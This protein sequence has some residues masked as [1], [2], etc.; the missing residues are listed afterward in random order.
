VIVLWRRISGGFTAG[1]QLALW[2]ALQGSIKEQIAN[3]GKAI[4]NG[5]SEWIELIRLVGSLELLPLAEK[6]RFVELLN[7][8]VR[9]KKSQ[10]LHAGAWWSIG[11]L[12][13]RVPMYG[14]LSGVVDAERIERWLEMWFMLPLTAKDM[15]LAVMQA[16][17]RTGDRYRDIREA[18]R[19]EVLGWLARLDAPTH[20]MEL[21]RE[22]GQLAAHEQQEIFGEALPLGLRFASEE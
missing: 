2:Q 13:A 11:R 8:V 22:V 10:P 21:V 4:R 1:Q 18:S 3:R 14:P 6:V 19:Q 9:D 5:A 12:V 15:M 20:Y 17:R 16:A 7:E